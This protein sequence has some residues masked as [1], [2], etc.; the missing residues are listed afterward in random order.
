MPPTVPIVPPEVFIDSGGFIALHVPEDAYHE[1]A[2]SCRDQTLRFSRLYT[3]S[4]VIAETIAHIQRNNLLDQQSL[5]DLITDFLRPQKW[6][7][8]LPVD[9][10]VLTKSLHMVKARQD[11]NFSLVDATNIALM[12]KYRLDIIFS[13]DWFYEGFPIQRGYTNHFIKRVGPLA[14]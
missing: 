8:L 6:I 5:H 4:A 1:A 13:F 3:S 7:S 2:I 10:E 14:V 11:R 9:D 12:E